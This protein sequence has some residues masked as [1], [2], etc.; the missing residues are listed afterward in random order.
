LAL[1]KQPVRCSEACDSNEYFISKYSNNDKY[2][3]STIHTKDFVYKICK[4][5]TCRIED[6]Y[7]ARATARGATAAMTTT[8]GTRRTYLVAFSTTI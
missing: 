1:P 7:G 5:N 6:P 3:S 8:T 2:R 4:I